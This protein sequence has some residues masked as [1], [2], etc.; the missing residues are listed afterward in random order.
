MAEIRLVGSSIKKI[1]GYRNPNFDGKLS[2]DTKIKVL[3]IDRVKESKD[4][5]KIAYSFE[6]DYADLGNVFLEGNV[7][8]MSDTKTV[9]DILKSWESKDFGSEENSLISSIILQK[10]SI[11]LFALEDDLGLPPH[12]RMPKFNVKK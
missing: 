4:T 1:S 11:K 8:V 10:A 5:L 3:K 12:I 7:F 9:R 2:L 6:V